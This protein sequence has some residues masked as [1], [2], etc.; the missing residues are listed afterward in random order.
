MVPA[1]RWRTGFSA[2]WR[3][4]ASSSARCSALRL[5]FMVGFMASPRRFGNVIGGD[6][7]G[8]WP[9][10]PGQH[11]E[12]DGNKPTCIG[13]AKGNGA[14]GRVAHVECRV[15]VEERGLDLLWRQAMFRD[16]GCVAALV[17]RLVPFDEGVTQVHAMPPVAIAFVS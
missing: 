14:A 17:I 8:D 9:I 7:A 16:V 15:F 2:C 12:H 4:M 6:P 5:G 10:V 13:A 11:L 3:R 1:G